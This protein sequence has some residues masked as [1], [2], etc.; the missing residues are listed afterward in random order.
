MSRRTTEQSRLERYRAQQRADSEAR[1]TRA[2]DEAAAILD[3]ARG[4]PDRVRRDELYGMRPLTYGGFSEPQVIPDPIEI[5][6]IHDQIFE[7]VNQVQTMQNDGHLTFHEAQDMTRQQY[8]DI[9]DRYE[10]SSRRT[11]LENEQREHDSARRMREQY[12]PPS[13]R[14]RE[15][16]A[17]RGMREAYEQMNPGR[18]PEEMQLFG[19]PIVAEAHMDD[20]LIYV[21]RQVIPYLRRNRASATWSLAGDF[22]PQ[23]EQVI[24]RVEIENQGVSIRRGSN[25]FN[26]LEETIRRIRE[27]VGHSDVNFT[28]M[29]SPRTASR[30]RNEIHLRFGRNTTNAMNAAR[31]AVRDNTPCEHILQKEGQIF[32]DQMDM[33]LSQFSA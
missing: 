22:I 19:C 21:V 31:A 33:A 32:E 28:I 13:W 17:T 2:D 23:T 4:G 18:P 14:W 10:E 3:R 20:D 15:P 29:V 24:E 9:R 12:D 1:R 26:A 27:G 11:Q 25:P 7:H 30:L 8:E 6:R 16:D 5:R